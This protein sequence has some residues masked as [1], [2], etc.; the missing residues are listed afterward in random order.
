MPMKL[1]RKQSPS[2]IRISFWFRVPKI[3]K[4][5][6][7]VQ[8]DVRNI[9]AEFGE[10]FGP[11]PPLGNFWSSS[12]SPA[13]SAVFRQFCNMIFSSPYLRRPMSFLSDSTAKSSIFESW[14][15]QKKPCTKSLSGLG[16][17]EFLL[18]CCNSAR[19]QQLLWCENSPFLL[20]GFSWAN[21]TLRCF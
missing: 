13:T 20:I 1:G 8:E 12:S 14:K 15:Q 18:G 19:I 17:I 21:P 16:D 3:P 2:W 5:S 10:F 11:D 6:R 9:W 4:S 7:S